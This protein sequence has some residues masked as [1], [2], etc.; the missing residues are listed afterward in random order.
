V[1]KRRGFT[2]VELL[3]VIAII[4]VLMAIL[5]PALK[6]ARE[7][8]KRGVCLNNLKQLTLAWILYADDYE[9]KLPNSDV[10]YTGTPP[11]HT[12]WVQWPFIPPGPSI[13]NVTMN[14]WHNVIKAG[15]MYKYCKNVNLYRCPNAPKR[16][17]L[18]YAIVD[19]MNGF[20][21][22]GPETQELKITLI[23]QIRRTS[24]RM[25]FLD[26]SPPSPGTW[27]IKYMKEAW[28]DPPPKLHSKG[29]TFSF[30][31]GHSEFWKW[32]DPRTPKSVWDNPAPDEIPHDVDQ[33]G[34]EDLH[35]VQRAV[36]GGLGYTPS[37]S[38]Y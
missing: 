5:M 6:A 1:Y 26:E 14:E 15:Q 3:V 7:Q 2:L 25:V 16:Y 27:G 34:N 36:W 33:P 9:G 19:S 12:W 18:S 4:A 10:G 28:W 21:G 37:P 31:D 17:G 20:C 22:W 29:T 24:E 35:K 38:P 13:E 23:N 32:K 11:V 8:G 30:V